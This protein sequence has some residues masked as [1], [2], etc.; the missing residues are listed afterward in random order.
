MPTFPTIKRRSRR[1]DARWRFR[2]QGLTL[3][4]LLVATVVMV[5]VAGAIATTAMTVEQAQELS[6]GQASASQHGRVVINRIQESLHRAHANQYFPGCL[7]VS[8]TESTW[9][10]PDTLVVWNPV[11]DPIDPDGLPRW[12]EVTVY[13]PDPDA[14]NRL[15]EFTN[16]SQA[17]SVPSVDDNSA[18]QSALS[19]FIADATTK[20]VQLTDLLRVARAT[21]SR[22]RGAVRFRVEL[23]PSANEWSEYLAG[24]LNWDELSWVQGVHG[25]NTGMRQTW[26]SFELQL[27]RGSD[28][29]R[30][31]P[32]G[33]TALPF[34]GSAG[35]YFQLTK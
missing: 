25:S 3:A 28:A 13:A 31:D 2:R 11:G 17:T 27:M 4:E 10:F 18:W 34:F 15:M 14:P 19:L 5:M 35:V 33:Q 1:N 22:Q 23:H 8:E 26:C 21:T 7:V 20:K 9:T 16:N 6:V 32:A 24:N 29:Y 12:S 30:T